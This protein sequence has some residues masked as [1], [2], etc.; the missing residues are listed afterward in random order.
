MGMIWGGCPRGDV[1]EICV[2][3]RMSILVLVY[4]CRKAWVCMLD[5][6]DADTLFR[7]T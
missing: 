7:D 3:K 4:K 5:K 1:K 2:T 6:N